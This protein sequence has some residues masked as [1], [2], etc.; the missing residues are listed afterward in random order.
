MK[1]GVIIGA[2]RDAIHTINKAKEQG[3]YVVAIDGNPKA[4]GFEFADESINVDISDMDKV[5][6]AIEQIKPDFVLPV[7]IGRYLSTTGYVN[8]KYGLKGIKYDAT[9]LSTDK[10]LFHKKLEEDNLRQVK[11]Y[12]VNKD[13]KLSDLTMDYPAIMKPRY[14]SGSRDV[15]Y[16]NN[17]TELELAYNKVIDTNEDFVLEQAAVGTEYGV[18]GAVIDGQLFIT[19]IRKKVITPLPVRQAISSFSVVNNGSNR[20]LIDETYSCMEKVVK[21]LGY[22]NCLINADIIKNEEGIFV[23]EI[24]PR[25]S[26]HNLHNVFV[27]IASGIDISEEYIRFLKGEKCDFSPKNIRCVQIRFFDFQD[28]VIVRIPSEDELRASDKCNL[29]MWKCNINKSETMNKVVNGHSIMGRGFFIIEG[30]DEEDLK[31][32]SDWILSQFELR[33]LKVGE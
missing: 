25:P 3:I 15:Y 22:D 31:N 2:S 11:L 17:H 16:I 30:K 4:E 7:P 10:Y 19:L 13:A 20:C 18:D 6:E 9:N 8:E 21:C 27:P 33:H 24:A 1:K 32:Q 23:I 26:G 5:S 28:V 12:L 29:V 14:G